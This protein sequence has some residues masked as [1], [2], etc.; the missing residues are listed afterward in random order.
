MD[1]IKETFIDMNMCTLLQLHEELV[2]CY[3]DMGF[4]SKSTSHDFIHCIID[5]IDFNDNIGEYSSDDE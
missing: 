5:H 1:Q 4:L 3:V 2:E